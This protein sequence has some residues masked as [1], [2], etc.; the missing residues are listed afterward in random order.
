MGTWKK[1]TPSEQMGAKITSVNSDVHKIR[2]P[3]LDIFCQAAIVWLMPEDM[4]PIDLV[5]LE[6]D[7]NQ[8]SNRSNNR[9]TGDQ[10]HNN[11]DCFHHSCFKARFK[12]LKVLHA[13]NLLLDWQACNKS[14]LTSL[15]AEWAQIRC[16]CFIFTRLED[17]SSLSSYLLC[18]NSIELIH[19][20]LRDLAI[21]VS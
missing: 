9:K 17:K 10:P 21:S 2:F 13:E 4:P 12:C 15:I 11:N 20:T 5:L 1:G 16:F 8:C 7:T 6:N 3:C 14:S 18:K 19:A